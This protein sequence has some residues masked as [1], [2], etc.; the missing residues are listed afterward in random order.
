MCSFISFH[1]IC[2][3]SLLSLLFIS[4][5]VTLLINMYDSCFCTSIHPALSSVALHLMVDD[6]PLVSMLV[7]WAV[8][9][10]LDRR[11][12]FFPRIFF[13]LQDS[14]RCSLPTAYLGADWFGALSSCHCRSVKRNSTMVSIHH[15]VEFYRG[16]GMFPVLGW[17]ESERLT[18]C[19]SLEKVHPQ[20]FGLH[21]LYIMHIMRLSLWS[22]IITTDKQRTTRVQVS[23]LL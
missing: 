10:F 19:T 11:W 2:Y 12:L 9:E 4:L 7:R 3:Y 14:G 21:G 22:A 5:F 8:S 20:I 6:P 15:H 18:D 16:I 13:A 17:G 1:S 23:L